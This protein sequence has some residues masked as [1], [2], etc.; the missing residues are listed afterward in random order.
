VQDVSASSQSLSAMAQELQRVTAL[1]NQ[2]G[3]Q[4]K[5][6]LPKYHLALAA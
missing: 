3:A 5:A 4:A 6:D 1:F 2:D